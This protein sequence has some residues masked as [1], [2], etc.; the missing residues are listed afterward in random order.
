LTL[1]NNNNN[2]IVFSKENITFDIKDCDPEQIKIFDKEN[3]YY[4][5]N[6]ICDDNCPITNGRAVCVKNNDI[7][8][9]NIKYNKC[10]CL[11][12]FIGEQCQLQD[13]APLKYYLSIYIVIILKL[14]ILF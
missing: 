14:N 12:G 9:N 8:I 2:N 13:Y 6:P 7:H 4:C 11:D 3:F 1:D 5:E 10:E